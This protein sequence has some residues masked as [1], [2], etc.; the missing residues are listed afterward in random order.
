M[1]TERRLIA[2]ALALTR[3]RTMVGVL[4]GEAFSLHEST[5]SEG[6]LGE[7]PGFEEDPC[8]T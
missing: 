3:V 4:K 7:D 1:S 5:L 6:C 2:K 8:R